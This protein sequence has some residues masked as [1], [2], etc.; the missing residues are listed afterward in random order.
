MAYNESSYNQ[1]S[2]SETSI[3]G[4]TISESSA[5]STACASSVVYT[6]SVLESSA[7]SESQI[8]D[9]PGHGTIQNATAATDSRSGNI[10]YAQNILENSTI[11]TVQSSALSYI[12]TISDTTSIS[13][14][15]TNILYQINS[16]SNSTNLSDLYGGTIIYPAVG[17]SVVLIGYYSVSY[18]T[19]IAESAAIL[20]SYSDVSAGITNIVPLTG[21]SDIKSILQ[22]T[23]NSIVVSEASSKINAYSEVISESLA[24]V[25]SY[26]NIYSWLENYD[27]VQVYS[28]VLSTSSSINTTLE[29]LQAYLVLPDTSQV[30]FIGSV[31]SDEGT[32][33]WQGDFEI[34]LNAFN[35]L[36][37]N[38]PISCVLESDTYVFIVDGKSS[39]ISDEYTQARYSVKAISPIALKQ[40][41]RSKGITVTYDQITAA[42]SIVESLLD[43]FSIDWQILEWDI[44]A[45]RL[46]I[47]DADILET[48]QKIVAAPGGVIES[49]PDGSLV[50]R[51]LYPI[52][53]PYYIS[54][55]ADIISTTDR[56]IF[57]YNEQDK[58]NDYFN[59]VRVSDV[60]ADDYRDFIE[61]IEELSILKGFTY[62]FDQDAYITHTSSNA[63]MLNRLGVEYDVVGDT[64]EEREVIEI[65]K[66]QGQT[67][68]PIFSI[69][70]FTYLYN[71]L[72]GVSFDLDGTTI[73]TSD[74]EGYSLVEVVYTTRYIKYDV[75]GGGV[76]E[77]QFLLNRTIE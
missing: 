49:N 7:T 12:N 57:N 38:D 53:P 15:Q 27:V 73:Y 70:S 1:E 14:V 71:N 74:T 24:K 25:D 72:G 61:Y 37:I 16:T 34:E 32:P 47:E 51:Y 20:S 21:Y 77:A 66:G 2:Y 41:P 58:I 13:A 22:L 33:Y 31:Y 55:S 67:R 60:P 26:S 29:S 46:S 5:T 64:E 45:N 23:S 42:K 11:A 39:S 52:S 9:Q 68:Y 75:S 63:V 10:S 50:V 4:N 30:P 69:G 43:G 48:V 40:K 6:S 59:K 62:P 65:I 56:D 17:A 3:Y 18:S 36:R 44:L 8:G 19:V 54:T 28:E 35:K 76:K